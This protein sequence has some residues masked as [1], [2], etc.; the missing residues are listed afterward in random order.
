[1]RTLW[2]D[3]LLH[4]LNPRA[5]WW[6]RARLWLLVGL[7]LSGAWLVL[8]RGT[9]EGGHGGT[10]TWVRQA[11]G[12]WTLGWFG[13]GCTAELEF[14]G[15]AYRTHGVGWSK[16]KTSVIPPLMRRSLPSTPNPGRADRE[17]FRRQGWQRAIDQ[18]MSNGAKTDDLVGYT[19]LRD[20]LRE[21]ASGP[22]LAPLRILT[23]L[24]PSVVAL[25][26]AVGLLRT[27]VRIGHRDR[28]RRIA[29]SRCPRCDYSL[30][31]LPCRNTCPEC[32]LG[33]LADTEDSLRALGKMQSGALHGTSPPGGRTH[34]ARGAARRAATS[35][36]L[37]NAP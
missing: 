24:A 14:H 28:L 1:M 6:A 31:G 16:W 21:Y 33:I 15:I 4:I 30:Q 5:P 27:L 12:E 26:L 19:L 10:F 17:S 22:L 29:Q 25:T 36:P 37:E 20:G 11:S 13:P 8:S 34:V 18:M 35:Q 2:R 32:G 7:L 3:S 23:I 9:H